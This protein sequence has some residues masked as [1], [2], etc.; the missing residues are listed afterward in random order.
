MR[1]SVLAIWP[2]K[3]REEPEKVPLY[4]PEKWGQEEEVLKLRLQEVVRRPSERL[5]ELLPGLD[6]KRLVL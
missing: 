1:K 4:E 2:R 3:V 5:H 6:L